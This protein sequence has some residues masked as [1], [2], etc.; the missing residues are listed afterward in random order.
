MMGESFSESLAQETLESLGKFGEKGE[1]F[2][3]TYGSDVDTHWVEHDLKKFKIGQ[4]FKTL[5]P[6]LIGCLLSHLRLWKLCR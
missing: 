1:K 3:A 5:N 2:P 6:G 4:K